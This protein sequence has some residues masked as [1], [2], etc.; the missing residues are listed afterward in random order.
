MRISREKVA[1]NREHLVQV[2][3]DQFRLHGIDGVGVADLMKEA[4]M[5]LGSFYGYFDSKEHLVSEC[6]SNAISDVKDKITS[7]LS[8]PLPNVIEKSVD[9]YLSTAHRDEVAKGCGLAALGS[10]F[11]HKTKAVHAAATPELISLFDGMAGCLPGGSRKQKR[12]QSIAMMASLMGGLILSRMTD[13][14]KLSQDILEAVK[15]SL[16]SSVRAGQ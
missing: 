5:S 2:A 8:R 9:E 16:K 6:C 11:A 3:T 10:E 12:Q 4:G 14:E 7:A 15:A 1:E 13:D